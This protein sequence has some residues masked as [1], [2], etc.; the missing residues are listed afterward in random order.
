[1]LV[2][3]YFLDTN[4]LFGALGA[5]ILLTLA[6]AG[7]VEVRWSE[8]VLNELRLALARYGLSRAK[9]ERRLVQMC[10]AFPEAMVPG[11][12]T[13]T[14]PADLLPD[15]DD[16][17][18]VLGAMAGDCRAVVTWNVKDFPPGRLA[19]LGL[20]VVTLDQL[21]SG[22]TMESPT[23]VGELLDEWLSR[24]ARPAY[25]RD[26]LQSR[27]CEVGLVRFAAALTNI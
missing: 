10:A 17:P 14:L 24:R 8:Y 1:M 3:P 16:L 18:I 5:D 9:T 7:L 21:L 26:S 25:D 19:P 13:A 11:D 15:R 20:E 27:I 22:V 2:R 23:E 4:V 12:R 6:S